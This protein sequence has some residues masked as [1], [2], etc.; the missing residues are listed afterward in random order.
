MLNNIGY[1][2]CLSEIGPQTRKV[3]IQNANDKQLDAICSICLNIVFEKIDLNADMLPEQ[4]SIYG[5][6]MLLCC[7]TDQKGGQQKIKSAKV[8]KICKHSV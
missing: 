5:P 8:S 2:L 4:L 7:Q 3:L 6:L 1:L